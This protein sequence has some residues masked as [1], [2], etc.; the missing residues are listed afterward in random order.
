[1]LGMGRIGI[2]RFWNGV[3]PGDL[4]KGLWYS[5]MEEDQAE[6]QQE[7]EAGAT[8]WVCRHCLCTI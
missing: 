7:K 3:E 4:G 5:M 1:M 6:I 2:A 8:P